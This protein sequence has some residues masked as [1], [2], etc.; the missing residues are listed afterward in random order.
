MEEKATFKGHVDF[1]NSYIPTL[2]VDGNVTL[3]GDGKTRSLYIG[4]DVDGAQSVATIR[5]GDQASSKVYVGASIQ[6]MQ[7][8]PTAL[9]PSDGAVENIK[10][11]ANGHGFRDM[12]IVYISNSADAAGDP[13]PLTPSGQ[14]L[15]YVESASQD[16]F[17]STTAWPLWSNTT[18]CNLQS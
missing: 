14:R 15:F 2:R 7:V 9:L 17:T 8:F 11:I 3:N 10:V 6:P 12:D 4:A 18:M 1:S 16:A 5:L 13:A